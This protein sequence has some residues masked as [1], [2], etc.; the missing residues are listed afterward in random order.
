MKVLALDVSLSTGFAVVTP[1]A[2]VA[3]GLIKVDLE[4]LPDRIR[5]LAQEV[6]KLERRFK[7]DCIVLEQAYYG[8]NPKVTSLLN[9]LQGGIVPATKAPVSYLSALEARKLVLGNGRATKEDVFQWVVNRYA[10]SG[11]TFKAGNDLTDAILLGLALLRK[12]A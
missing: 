10:L 8:V 7:P 6:R 2:L 3:Y 1:S 4:G 11:L 9:Q 5:F 12:G